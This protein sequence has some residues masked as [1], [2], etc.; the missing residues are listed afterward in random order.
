MRPTATVPPPLWRKRSGRRWRCG[1]M[2]LS[3]VRIASR[4]LSGDEVV[5]H[6]LGTL[7]SRAARSLLLTTPALYRDR[8]FE[9]GSVHHQVRSAWGDSN[10][11]GSPE[12]APAFRPLLSP[13]PR[14]TATFRCDCLATERR[15]GGGQGGA[16]T[17]ED[18]C[19]SY[20]VLCSSVVGCTGLGEGRG[21]PEGRDCRA[22]EGC[23]KPFS[24]KA[25]RSV[26][27][28]L[29]HPCRVKKTTHEEV[30]RAL[31]EMSGRPAT[32]TP[33]P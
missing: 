11:T 29:S 15:P 18:S 27:A 5:S 14:S 10:H 33:E 12:P 21:E 25:R 30:R 16:S 8:Q 17:P 32:P 22:F 1:Q 24:A 6:A 28:A 9:R 13:R 26:D 31:V 23:G 2:S 7:Y 4:Q 3:R 20:A 19:R